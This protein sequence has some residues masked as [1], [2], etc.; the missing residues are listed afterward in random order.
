MAPPGEREGD[1]T[2]QL[3][4]SLVS[5]LKMTLPRVGGKGKKEVIL[6]GRYKSSLPNRDPVAVASDPLGRSLNTAPHK[7]GTFER[8]GYRPSIRRRP[9]PCGR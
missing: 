9:M 4:A 5:M 8:V 1:V 2:N 6:R 7:N 3:A